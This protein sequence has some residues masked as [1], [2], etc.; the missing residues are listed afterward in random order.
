MQPYIPGTQ[1]PQLGFVSLSRKRLVSLS[2]KFKNARAAHVS[3]DK[4]LKEVVPCLKCESGKAASLLFQFR[5]IKTKGSVLTLHC[6]GCSDQR[7]ICPLKILLFL[8]LA[9]I[10]YLLCGSTSA[11]CGCG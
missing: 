8:Y 1:M 3:S 4:W 6:L 5:G 9:V 2:Q 10:H 7:S 11:L